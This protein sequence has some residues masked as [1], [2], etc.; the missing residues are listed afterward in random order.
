LTGKLRIL[1]IHFL[2]CQ[3]CSVHTATHVWLL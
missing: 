2:S 1:L 3:T